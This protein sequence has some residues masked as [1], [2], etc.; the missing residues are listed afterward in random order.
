MGSGSHSLT[1][2]R[3]YAWEKK[4]FE[5]VKV[6]YESNILVLHLVFYMIVCISWMDDLHWQP[7]DIRLMY[8]TSASYELNCIR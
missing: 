2:G 6:E 5:E 3:L 1:L 4:L 7:N 8:L